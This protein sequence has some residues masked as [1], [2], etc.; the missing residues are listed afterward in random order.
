MKIRSSIL[1]HVSLS[2]SVSAVA[3]CVLDP[4]HVERIEGRLLF[5]FQN[6]YRVLD[7][8][9]IRLLDSANTQTV[10]ASAAGDKDGHFEIADAKP[11]KYILS[12]RSEALIP[13]S[14]DVEI[15]KAKGS[16]GKRLILVVL[17]ADATKECGGASIRVQSKA[18]VD[19]MLSIAKRPAH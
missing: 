15:A 13:V 9:E 3:Q 16:P 6:Q 4:I 1:L 19:R 8:G 10:V 18:E 12:A 11:G 7:K 14:V 2:L 17:A 5:G